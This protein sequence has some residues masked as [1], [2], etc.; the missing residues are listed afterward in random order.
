MDSVKAREI[1]A[2]LRGTA[3]G[4]WTIQSYV[5]NGKSAAVFRASRGAEIAAVKIFDDDLIARYGD[6]T[7]IARI[8]RELELIGKQHPH[9]VEILGGGFDDITGN[10]YVIMSFVEGPS[11]RKCLAEIPAANIPT[12][13]QQLAQAAKFL[14]DLGIVHRD[15]KP[16]N[17]IVKGSYDDLILLD[18][19]VIRP[20]TGST[21]TDSSGILEFI[22]T[23][24]YSSPEFLLREEEDSLEGWRSLTFYQI[25]AVLHD[26][27]MRRPIFADSA[28]PYAR[29]VNAVQN[30][31]PEIQNSAV[32]QHLVEIARCCLLK[33]WR[34]RLRLVSWES[35]M[36]PVNVPMGG[37]GQSAKQRV[38]N[39]GATA[40]AQLIEREAI[41][42]PDN[43][44]S[45][46]RLVKEAIGFLSAA[47]RTIRSENSVLPPLQVHPKVPDETGFAI[48]FDRTPRFGLDRDLSIL[49][50]VEVLDAA[51]RV[52]AIWSCG[53][54]G[55]LP[56]HLSGQHW[57]MIFQGTYDG[58]T[59]YSS[60]E[61]CVYDL[62]DQAQSSSEDVQ[63]D[64]C[65]W[66]APM[67]K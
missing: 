44:V 38:T 29:L 36:P 18:L 3:I 22:G 6:N 67:E 24:Q 64:I 30:V 32:P 15:I 14:E 60:L 57:A 63:T 31:I 43:T 40:Q 27:I 10:H 8:N 28:T 52:V 48:Q 50:K 19:G 37:S 51:A 33:D 17:I 53:C 23:L 47:C 13:T 55:P 25:G 61:A 16:D 21:L 42:P 9:L 59:M 45:R 49:I 54:I 66:V 7:Q 20:L 56:E 58:S 12:L 34:T 1:E 4:G 62:V 5:D 39:R 65:V 26:L 46:R 2:K 11:L 41:R 35:L